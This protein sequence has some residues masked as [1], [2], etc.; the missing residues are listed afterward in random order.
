MLGMAYDLAGQRDSAI[1]V[2]DRYRRSTDLTRNNVDPTFL[3]GAL[4][5]LGELYDAKGDAKHALEAYDMFTRLWS[6]ADPALQPRVKAVRARA[7]QVRTKLG[8]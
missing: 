8:A 6:S 5:R 7:E 2:L 1:A 3:A 4:K